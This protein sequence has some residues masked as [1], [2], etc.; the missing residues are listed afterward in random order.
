MSSSS[1]D[2]VA[3]PP[4]SEPPPQPSTSVDTPVAAARVESERTVTVN[5]SVVTVEETSTVVDGG[6][7]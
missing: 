1:P 4:P 6:G 3:D 7:V 2:T 5:G